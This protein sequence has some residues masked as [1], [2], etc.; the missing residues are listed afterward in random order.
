MSE[1]SRATHLAAPSIVRTQKFVTT[2]AYAPVVVSTA[3]VDACLKANELLDPKDYPLRDKLN[4]R[5]IGGSIEKAVGLAAKNKNKLFHGQTI[6]IMDAIHGGFATF[7][8]IVE[9]NGGQCLSWK[10]RNNVMVN[11]ARAGSKDSTDGGAGN[12]L[13]LVSDT[14][15]STTLWEKFKQMAERNGRTPRIVSAD[16]LIETALS[17][18]VRPTR[19]YVL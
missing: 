3:F 10:N 14:M 6:Y 8:T 16:W 9:A 15:E 2:I 19:D 17:Q 7:E 12:D 13:I 11:S 1:P 4:E 5:S 18:A